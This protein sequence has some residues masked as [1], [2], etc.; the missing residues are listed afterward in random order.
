[1]A[2]AYMILGTPVI[3]T[4]GS[5]GKSKALSSDA[6]D[7]FMCCRRIHNDVSKS[8]KNEKLF[9]KETYEQVQKFL[10]NANFPRDHNPFNMC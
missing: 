6:D 7:H 1:M 9:T 10:S 2:T 5:D 8:K 4:A 3:E